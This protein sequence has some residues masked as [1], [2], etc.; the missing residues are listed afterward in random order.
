MLSCSVSEIS[1]V[2]IW[3]STGDC[4]CQCCQGIGTVGTML[5][6]LVPIQQ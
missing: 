2:M 4:I 5:P 3:M 6:N 1:N